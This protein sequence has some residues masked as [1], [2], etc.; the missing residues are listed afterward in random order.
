MSADSDVAE[1]RAMQVFIAT[2]PAAVGGTR[3]MVGFVL[4]VRRQAILRAAHTPAAQAPPQWVS[5]GLAS[6]WVG[7]D[8]GDRERCADANL[9]GRSQ[10]AAR[11]APTQGR[12]GQTECVFLY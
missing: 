12:A 6:A 3:F 7:L 8:L 2:P 5:E 9:K 4:C 11:G 1:A 10:A